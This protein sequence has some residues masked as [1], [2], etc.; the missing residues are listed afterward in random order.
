MLEE[1]RNLLLLLLG[2]L[3]E[4]RV[5]ATITV[6]TTVTTIDTTITVTTI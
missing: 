3:L 1:S 6:C 2:K 5:I 4:R